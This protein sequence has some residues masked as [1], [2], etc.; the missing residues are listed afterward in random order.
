MKTLEHVM[1]RGETMKGLHAFARI[2]GVCLALTS[3][4]ILAAPR[5]EK[6]ESRILPSGPSLELPTTPTVPETSPTPEKGKDNYEVPP[7]FRY[8]EDP[9]AH[10][11]LEEVIDEDIP[12]MKA[13]ELTEDAAKRALDAFEE[14]FGKFPDEEIAKYPT[15]QEFADK[16]PLGRKF[17]AIIRKHGFSSVAEWNDI[18]A[19]IGFAVTSIEEGDDGEILTQIRETEQ[20]TDLPQERKEKLLNYLRVLIPSVNNRKVVKKLLED[21]VYSKKIDLLEGGGGE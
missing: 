15:L 14:V 10:K 3:N 6:D 20:R 16:S 11:S 17:A 8:E 13:V 5:P 4:V 19:N 12:N 7:D 9:S 21:P 2:A 18:I 1:P